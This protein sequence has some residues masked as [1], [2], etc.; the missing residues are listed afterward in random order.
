MGLGYRENCALSG[1]GQE[2]GDEFLTVADS[3][4]AGASQAASQVPVQEYG[5]QVNLESGHIDSMLSPEQAA[6]GSVD[7]TSS[8]VAE[9]ECARCG[10]FGH[11]AE[12]CTSYR[13]PPLRHADA[14]SRGVGPHMRQ[15]DTKQVL[16]MSIMGTAS[17]AQNNCLIDSLRQLL[18]LTVKVSKI[19]R[20]LQLQFRT[21]AK[22]VTTRN[23]LQF[24]FH[25]VAILR[26]MG[27]D[28]VHFTLICLDLAHT[29]HGDV[30]G[31]GARR[32]YLARQGQNHFIPLFWRANAR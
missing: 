10:R 29:G 30:I 9:M 25:A 8:S 27:F 4:C 26:H 31:F 23:Y 1:V 13:Q 28:P 5:E 16:A 7:G 21:G 18:D 32:V 22:K 15:V 17:G 24:D 6:S 2:F 20:A 3:I 14:S 11:L 19:R 12:D